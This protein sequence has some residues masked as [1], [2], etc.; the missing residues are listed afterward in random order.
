MYARMDY[1]C[2]HRCAKVCA[3][4][5]KDGLYSEQCPNWRSRNRTCTDSKL[6]LQNS[7]CQFC[8]ISTRLL[9]I[10]KNGLFVLSLDRTFV[11]SYLSVCEFDYVQL[12]SDELHAVCAY[13]P[14]RTHVHTR[15]HG[16]THRHT[17]FLSLFL[18]RSL[19]W[20][21]SLFLTLS[22]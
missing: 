17:L 13:T 14:E 10:S 3:H 1:A 2:I 12:M 6:L 16:H 19:S 18:S 11:C 20:S 22:L 7:M 15:R 8:Q 9:R 5:L 21:L 4:V